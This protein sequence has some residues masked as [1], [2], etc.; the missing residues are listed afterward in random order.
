MRLIDTEA[1]IEL[2]RRK[3][4]LSGAISI[5]TL[6][7]VLRGVKAEKRTA[8][9]EALEESFTVI[10]L[11]NSVILAYCELYDKLRSEGEP[12][13]DADLLIAATAVAHDLELKSR[14]KH[15]EKLRKHGL[16]LE[17]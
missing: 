5:V 12:V 6:I 8:V 13:P 7:E 10:G 3:E 1:L 14:D 17:Q 15:F 11:D 16:K 9:K 2:L 4:H